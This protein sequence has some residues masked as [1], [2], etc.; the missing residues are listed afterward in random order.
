MNRK[1]GRAQKHA[2]AENTLSQGRKSVCR[3]DSGI[4]QRHQAAAAIERDQV[5]TA[6]DVR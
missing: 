4:E 2:G 6:A 1:A 5:I 3:L